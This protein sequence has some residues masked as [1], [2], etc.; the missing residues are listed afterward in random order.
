MVWFVPWEHLKMGYIHHTDNPIPIT[1]PMLALLEEMDKRRINPSADAFVFPGQWSND[2]TLN[3]ANFNQFVRQQLRW[4]THITIH[5]FRSTLR[6]WCRANKY[7]E[8]W[9]DIQVDHSL[10]NKTSQSYGT[11]KLI[12]ERR[13][14]MEKWGEYC[15]KPAPVPIAADVI[16]ISDKRRSK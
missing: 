15:S 11:D 16:N 6:D 7:P 9:W 10:G 3:R 1:K 2:G 14:M 13:G 12:E 8:V 5:G 4:E